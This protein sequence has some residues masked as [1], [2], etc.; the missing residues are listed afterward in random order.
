MI[1]PY[2]YAYMSAKRIFLVPIMFL[3]SW[4]AQA[5][6]QNDTVLFDD[7]SLYT[8]QI[9]DSLFNGNGKMIYSDNTIYNGEWKNG[10]WEGKGELHFPDGDFYQGEFHENEFNGQGVYNYRNGARYEGEWKNGRFDGAGTM[11]YADGSTYTGEWKNDLKEGAGVLYDASDSS[12]FKGYFHND[13]YLTSDHEV[14]YDIVNGN[15]Q[16]TAVSAN[17]IPEQDY[18]MLIYTGF[19]CGFNQLLSINLSAGHKT[20]L[21]GGFCAGVALVRKGKG[22]PSFEIETKETF[23]PETGEYVSIYSDKVVLVDWDDYMDEVIS[24]KT[25]H[26]AQILAEAGWRWRRLA[27]GGGIGVAIKQSIRNCMGGKGSP[28]NNGELYYREKITGVGLGYRL[29]GDLCIRQFYENSSLYFRLG[30]GNGDG[31]FMGFGLSF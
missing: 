22:K 8:G 23:D 28:F 3:V 29:F 21:F 26:K 10:M 24:E 6:V 14:Y 5:Q 9:S 18:E 17:K 12:L 4:A 15:T 25:Y 2:L 11:R 16:T 19:T 13:N 1:F 27:L 20:G 31:V 30:Y 7:G